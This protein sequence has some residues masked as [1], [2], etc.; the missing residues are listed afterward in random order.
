MTSKNIKTIEISALNEYASV[1]EFL[2]LIFCPSKNRLKKHFDKKFLSKKLIAKQS[3]KLPIDFVNEGEINPNYDGPQIEIV[4]EDHEV[5]VFNKP[6]QIFVH[7]LKYDE[8]NNCLSFMRMYINNGV[9][10]KINKV[11][12]DRGLLYRL[13]FETS[14]LLIYIKNEP[15]YHYLRD[16]FHAIAKEKIY[17]SWVCGEFQSDGEYIHYLRPSEKAGMKMLAFNKSTSEC[18]KA[19]LN[20][21]KLKYDSYKNQTLVEIALKTGHRHQIR[22]Q[23]AALGFPIVGDI[24]YGGRP[25]DRLFLHASKYTISYHGET[26]N[27]TAISP[28]F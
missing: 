21:K 22:V 17:L 16:H 14:G 26:R 7:P 12:Y 9:D 24:L 23:L 10:L 11:H 15:L 1:Q 6:H 13:D 18:E 2:E 8:S 5:I 25:A 3:L 20:V 28:D 4:F 19:I 27:F